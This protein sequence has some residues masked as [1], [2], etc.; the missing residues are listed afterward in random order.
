M[1][2]RTSD[3]RAAAESDDAAILT[4]FERLALEA[5]R[6]IMN[7]FDAGVAFETKADQSPVTEADRAAE[8]IILGGLRA[9]LPGLICV[10]EEECAAGLLPTFQGQTLLLIDPLDGTK[11]FIRRGREFTVNIAL[12]REG[13]P[14]IGVVYAPALGQFYAARPGVAFEAD[15]SADFAL[16]GRRPLVVRPRAEPPTIVAT[17]S[18]RNAATDSYLAEF[19]DARI[20]AVGS[21]LKFC[22][23]AAGRA[24]LYPRIGPTMEW[25]TAA[26]DAVLRAAGGRTC[27]FGGGLLRYGK[28]GRATEPDFVNPAFLA[29]GG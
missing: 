11:E 12:V 3:T 15:V 2:V 9:S 29:V 28:R 5:G 13:V 16:L 27:Y 24:D 10:A 25:D 14:E 4:L 6:V 1:T 21:S 8:R 22:M 18:H 26:G 20:L 19:P 17:R 7:I 23:V